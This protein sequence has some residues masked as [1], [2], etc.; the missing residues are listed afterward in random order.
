MYVSKI[1][2]IRE[3]VLKNADKHSWILECSSKWDICVNN[4]ITQSVVV[5]WLE[6]KTLHHVQQNTLVFI[7]EL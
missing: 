7:F 1:K 4:P 6:Q 5:D 2:T 3:K